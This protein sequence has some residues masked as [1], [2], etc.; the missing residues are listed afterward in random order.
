MTVLEKDPH[1]YDAHAPGAK[2][3]AGK[4]LADLVLG[5]FAHALEAVIEVGT[6]GARKYTESGWVSVPDGIR[7]YGNARQRHYLKRKKGEL[8][9]P[10]TQCLHLA[11]EAWNVLAEL[12]LTLRAAA[13]QTPLPVMRVDLA[14]YMAPGRDH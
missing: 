6:V 7:R 13:A 12:E 1:G 10:D 5:D 2:L 11:Q 3:D 4:L 9:D 14:K 8:I